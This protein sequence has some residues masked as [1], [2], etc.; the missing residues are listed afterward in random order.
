[1]CY[2]DGLKMQNCTLL[3]TTLAF[4]YS[5]VEADINGKVESVINP[6]SGSITADEIGELILEKDRID[7]SLTKITVRDKAN[8]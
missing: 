3:N 2:I 6:T 4:E 8:A 7:P 5:K 1:M